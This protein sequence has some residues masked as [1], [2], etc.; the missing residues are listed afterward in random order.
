MT[1]T[2][3]ASTLSILYLEDE[4][5]LAVDFAGQLALLGFGEVLVAHSLEA[6]E[7]ALAGRRV[8][9]AFLDVTLGGGESSVALGRRLAAEGTQVV[10]H[11]GY[12]RSD[13]ADGLKGFDLLEKPVSEAALKRS[14]ARAVRAATGGA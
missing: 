5:L 14:M 6:A 8:D 13:I 9:L 12:G 2:S 11:S 1:G 3:G 4:R 7:A 10:F